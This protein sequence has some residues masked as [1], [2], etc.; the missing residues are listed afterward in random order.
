MATL[1]GLASLTAAGLLGV[2][3]P[4]VGVG[5]DED[6]VVSFARCSLPIR[7]PRFGRLDES[8]FSVVGPF[9]IVLIVLL[10]STGLPGLFCLRRLR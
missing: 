5:K 6:E 4:H 2:I 3:G 8:T 10:Q 9:L 1:F 7:R